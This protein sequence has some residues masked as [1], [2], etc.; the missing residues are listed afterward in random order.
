MAG[1]GVRPTRERLRSGWGGRAGQA[2]DP[3]AT[4]TVVAG[5]L[6]D[7]FLVPVRASPVPSVVRESFVVKFFFLVCRCCVRVF[8]SPGA[9]KFLFPLLNARRG[10]CVELGVG[11]G[12]TRAGCLG[13][14]ED[15]SNQLLPKKIE[16]R[17]QE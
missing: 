7:V 4:D 6:A 10:R 17:S 15:V 14:G 3:R 11:R 16:V 13:H 1:I 9:V 8:A 5:E 2:L 12:R